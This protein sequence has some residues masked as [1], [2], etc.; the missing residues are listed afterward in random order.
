MFSLVGP[1]WKLI[2]GFTLEHVQGVREN[3]KCQPKYG[4]EN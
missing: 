3:R 1:A 4:E 2:L